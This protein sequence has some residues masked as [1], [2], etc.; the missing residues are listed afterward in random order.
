MLVVNELDR[1]LA[2]RCRGRIAFV[3]GRLRCGWER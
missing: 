1:V 3:G 2:W